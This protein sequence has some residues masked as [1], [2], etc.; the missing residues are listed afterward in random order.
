MFR[1]VEVSWM[2]L[3]KL[4]SLPNIG[5]AKWYICIFLLRTVVSHLRHELIRAAHTRYFVSVR[6]LLDKLLD[7]G[8]VLHEGHVGGITW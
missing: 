2:E 1:V 5:T 4:S 6:E 7:V 3:G 8:I